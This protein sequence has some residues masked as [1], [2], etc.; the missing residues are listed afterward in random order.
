MPQTK[1]GYTSSMY[2]YMAANNTGKDQTAQMC[3]LIIASAVRIWHTGL[4]M[5]QL[6]YLFANAVTDSANFEACL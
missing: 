4:P 6:T 2:T 1:L 5:I 3:S